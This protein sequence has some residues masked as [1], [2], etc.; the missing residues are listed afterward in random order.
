MEKVKVKI[1]SPILI[2][3]KEA[4]PNDENKGIYIIHKHLANELIARRRALL[5]DVESEINKLLENNAKNVTID[6][7]KKIAKELSIKFNPN[8]GIQK[9]SEKIIEDI[10]TK[11]KDLVLEENINAK[12]AYEAFKAFNNNSKNSEITL[13]ELKAIA[14]TAEIAIEDGADFDKIKEAVENGLEQYASEL[15]VEISENST[16]KELWEK[17]EEKLKSND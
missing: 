3:G 10:K 4:A 12:A 7:L 14:S 16:I 9:L 15:K 17:I 13:E 11:A 2:D 8:I 6:D 1:L 5:L